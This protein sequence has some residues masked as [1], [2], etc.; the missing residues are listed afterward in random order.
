MTG[1]IFQDPNE[2]RP[3][4]SA[5]SSPH[6]VFPLSAIPTASKAPRRPLW[7]LPAKP[8]HEKHAVVGQRTRGLDIAATAFNYR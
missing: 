4:L 5:A 7:G 2:V 3:A 1:A 8:D 6:S